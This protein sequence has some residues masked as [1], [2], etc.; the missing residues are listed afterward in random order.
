MLLVLQI[1][2]FL[3]KCML[4]AFTQ[5]TK[6]KIKKKHWLKFL[7]NR[8]F[9]YSRNF[10]SLLPFLNIL[11]ATGKC[12]L[13]TNWMQNLF[14]RELAFLKYFLYCLILKSECVLKLYFPQTT[15]R[16]ELHGWITQWPAVFC[17][18]RSFTNAFLLPKSF[19]ANRLSVGWNHAC[20]WFL[21]KFDDVFS[22]DNGI[23]GKGS[24]F[25]VP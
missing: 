5:A 6:R 25:G 4:S 11:F 15:H 24:S 1:E 22:D 21:R 2:F 16:K 8:K 3:L 12:L 10:H 14:C 23:L 19:I 17:R 9:I 18:I 20:N 13:I 7:A